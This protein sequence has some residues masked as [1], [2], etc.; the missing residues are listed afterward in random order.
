[1][2][3]E[4]IMQIT[5]LSASLVQAILA[6]SGNQAKV[7]QLAG[8]LGLA[9]SLFIRF[10]NS[11]TDMTDLDNQIKEAIAANRGLTDAQVAAWKSRDD[12]TDVAAAK[13]LKDHPAA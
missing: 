2:N 10:V 11:N 4:A 13:W 3:I 1:M 6:N 5:N 8:Y 9:N 7:N 12:L